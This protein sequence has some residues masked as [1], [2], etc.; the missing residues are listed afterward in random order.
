[1]P[2]AA[3]LQIRVSVSDAVVLKTYEN[4]LNHG[5]KGELFQ[6]FCLILGCRLRNFKILKEALVS[7]GM[8]H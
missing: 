6:V 5:F 3:W 2:K 8:V 7:L 1:M 4:M